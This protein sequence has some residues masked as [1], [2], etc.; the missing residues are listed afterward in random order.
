MNVS[1][2]QGLSLAA[3]PGRR[4]VAAWLGAM[5]GAGRSR[6]RGALVPNSQTAVFATLSWLICHYL[7]GEPMPIFAPIATFLC[8][9]FSRNRRPRKVVELGIGATVG[10]LAGEVL[11]SAFGFGWW[12]L[13][14]MFAVL[15]LVG[16]FL[17][18]SDLLTFQT[19]IN[20]VVVAGLGSIALMPGSHGGWGRWADALIGSLVA[21]VATAILPS[22]LTTRPRR[23]A[24]EAL[25]VIADAIES[26]ARVLTEGDADRAGS[27]FAQLAVARDQLTEGRAAQSSASDT[28]ALNPRFRGERAELAELDRQLQLGGRLL[29][30][31]QML[32][33]QARGMVSESGSLAAAGDYASRVA[34]AV[35]HL[36]GAIGHWNKPVLA[37]AEA[38]QLARELAPHV[39]AEGH[40]WRTAALISLLRACVVD[41]LQLTGLS[42]V[43]ARAAL[44]DNGPA[45]APEGVVPPDREG[46][47]A[48]QGSDMWGT[49][50]MPV[51]RPDGSDRAARPDGSDPGDDPPKP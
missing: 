7:L 19:A 38:E 4:Q 2:N 40:D 36:S 27:A 23:Y 43:Q 9:G 32:T 34:A 42:L 6:V 50:S 5:V 12:Q 30:S 28:A 16:R 11:S 25:A 35:R 29:V 1:G 47:D 3:R 17:D 13:L 37:R 48:E 21:L 46:L 24:S 31:V 8:M 41:L 10:V 49:T 44:V 15:P 33:R 39:I 14:V 18:D 22:S 45:Q 51:A 20:A 26:V